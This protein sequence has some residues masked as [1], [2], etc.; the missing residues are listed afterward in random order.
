MAFAGQQQARQV[1]IFDLRP[2][3]ERY[4]ELSE[5]EE[6]PSWCDAP[7]PLDGHLHVLIVLG[8]NRGL[9]RC[10]V[11]LHSVCWVHVTNTGIVNTCALTS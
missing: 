10:S 3:P 5:I 7:T 2:L 9:A 11:H 4:I 1:G 6:L 8:L